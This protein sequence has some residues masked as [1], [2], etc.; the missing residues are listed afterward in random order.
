LKSLQSGRGQRSW[1]RRHV[2]DQ[3]A[4]YQQISRTRTKLEC[5]MLLPVFDYIRNMAFPALEQVGRIFSSAI[6]FMSSN[7]TMGESLQIRSLR[8]FY[9]GG[10]L[11]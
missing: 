3:L 1:G 10:I 8:I 4:T 2:D 5:T 7:S 6:P 9:H 11:S